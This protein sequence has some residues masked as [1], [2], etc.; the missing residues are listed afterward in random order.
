M[1]AIIA[2]MQNDQKPD[3]SLSSDKNKQQNLGSLAVKDAPDEKPKSKPKGIKQFFSKLTKKQKII[4]SIVVLVLLVGG[5]ASALLLKQDTPPPPPP[6]AKVEAPPKTTE[7]SRLTGIEY[8]L[9]Q[10]VNQRTVTGIMIENSPDARPQSGLKDAGVVYEAVI[11]AGITRFLALF[12]DIAPTYVGPVRSVR[13]PYLDFLGPYDAGIAHVGGSGQALNE[14]KA[15]GLKDLDQFANPAPYWRER[16]RYAP[17]NM[18]T[19]VTKLK[20]VETEKGWVPSQYPA[21]LRGA[22]SKPASPVAAG[23]VNIKMSSALYNVS[24]TYDGATNTYK[25]SEGNRPHVDA[26]SN[27]QLAP[28][29]VIL[30][31]IPRSIVGGYSVYPVNS[32]GK[33]YVFQNGAVTEGTWSKTSR[34]EQFVFTDAAGQPL[35]LIAGQTWITIAEAAGNVSY[36]P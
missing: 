7:A 18:Y 24:Y 21:L 6:P 29:V 23:T 19:D 10:K 13:P 4:T 25:R 1:F 22:E 17:H 20:T 5:T 31:I 15:E 9:D 3:D 30:P 33:V 27:T 14:I 35:K 16:T 12:Q 34:K 32:S 11:E 36:T 2:I 8:P 28:A 26:K